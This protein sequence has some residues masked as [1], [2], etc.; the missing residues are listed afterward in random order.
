[1]TGHSLHSAVS[2]CMRLRFRSSQCSAYR[3]C[4]RSLNTRSNV[5]GGVVT[6][7]LLAEA[8]RVRLQR[9]AHLFDESKQFY[10][11]VCTEALTRF[12][13]ADAKLW[14]RQLEHVRSLMETTSIQIR[15]MSLDDALRRYLLAELVLLDSRRL[16]YEG[17]QMAMIEQP[18]PLVEAT[19]RQFALA[20]ADA[21]PLT[22]DTIELLVQK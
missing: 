19:R 5:F 4:C 13:S 2:K 14:H 8:M 9:Q 3:R 22:T 18:Q 20:W 16:F 21:M 11:L 7:G 6:G 1:M 15:T 10:F 12:R 17:T